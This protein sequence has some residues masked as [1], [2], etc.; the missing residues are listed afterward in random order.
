[1]P[2][3][4]NSMLY[5]RKMSLASL[6]KSISVLFTISMDMFCVLWKR[7]DTWFNELADT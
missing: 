4:F 3:S 6:I 5:T 2:V 7:I 1:M